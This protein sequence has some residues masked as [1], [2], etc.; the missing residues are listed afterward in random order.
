M[1]CHLASW[2]HCH[3]TTHWHFVSFIQNAP[4]NISH[5]D[6]HLLT[7]PNTVGN[8]SSLSVTGCQATIS[9]CTTVSFFLAS[10]SPV[11]ITCLLDALLST[12]QSFDSIFFHR[13]FH[14][15]FS[16]PVRYTMSCLLR[17]V[18]LRKIR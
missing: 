4:H 13:I 7:V 1:L 18:F 5:T 10:L 6:A 9:F 16:P 15:F 8:V 2:A 11:S 17:L 14:F 3:W 12:M